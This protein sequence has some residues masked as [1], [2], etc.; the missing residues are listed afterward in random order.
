MK[1]I[2]RGV[3]VFAFASAAFAFVPSSRV[4]RLSPGLLHGDINV[5]SYGVGTVKA[6]DGPAL[7]VLHV[8]ETFANRADLPWTIELAA[9]KVSF[10]DAYAAAGPVFINSDVNTLPIAVVGRGQTRIVDLYFALPAQIT[11]DEALPVF[12]LSYGLSTPD[13]RYEANA[14]FA[15]SKR[16]PRPEERAPEP[17]WARFWWSDPAYPWATYRRAPGRLIPR[18]PSKIEIIHVPRGLYE[19]MPAAAPDED[20]ARITECDEW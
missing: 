5:A 16:W 8:R 13:R 17:G 18:P 9:T 12:A 7:S 20:L 6:D 4:E 15:P 10:G 2:T 11:E 1:P 19:E 3:T 14:M